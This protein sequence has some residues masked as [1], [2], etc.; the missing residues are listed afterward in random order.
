MQVVRFDTDAAVTEYSRPAA[1]RVTAGDPVQGVRN[2]F[3]DGSGQF[4]CGI[5][6]SSVGSWKVRYTE[7]ELCHL[8][9]GHV[10]LTDDAG[11]VQDFRAGDSFV[12]PCGFS[13]LWEVLE[14][15]EKLYAIFEAVPA[16]STVA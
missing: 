13:G 4:F 10:R 3:T 5:W 9:R 2:M 6:Q 1:D 14:P 16:P 11:R 8:L 12:V 7:N 15:A